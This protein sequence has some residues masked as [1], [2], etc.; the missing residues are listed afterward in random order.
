MESEG[1]GQS[2]FIEDVDGGCSLV[3]FYIDCDHSLFKFLEY[4]NAL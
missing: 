3:H 1:D 2:I 4:T